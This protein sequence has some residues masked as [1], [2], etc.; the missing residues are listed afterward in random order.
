MSFTERL[1]D[2]AFWLMLGG[3]LLGAM[4]LAGQITGMF[5]GPRAAKAKSF[6][7]WAIGLLRGFG[8]GTYKDEPGSGSLPFKGD[9]GERVVTTENIKVV[10]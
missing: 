1:T 4:V 10:P 7:D 6:F 8:L 9:T 3:L 5:D 2:P